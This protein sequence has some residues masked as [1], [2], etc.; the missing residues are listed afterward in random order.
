MSEYVSFE[1]YEQIQKSFEDA[2]WIAQDDESILGPRCFGMDQM[3]SDDGVYINDGDNDYMNQD[4][5]DDECVYQG[6]NNGNTLCTN[7]QQASQP[8]N[9]GKHGYTIYFD[10]ANELNN[11]TSLKCLEVVHHIKLDYLFKYIGTHIHYTLNDNEIAAICSYNPKEFI[12]KSNTYAIHVIPGEECIVTDYITNLDPD[13]ITRLNKLALKSAEP[14]NSCDPNVLNWLIYCAKTLEDAI[15]HV[16]QLHGKNAIDFSELQQKNSEIKLLKYQPDKSEIGF[17]FMYSVKY[18]VWFVRIGFNTKDVEKEWIDQG[19]DFNKIKYNESIFEAYSNSLYYAKKQIVRDLDILPCISLARIDTTC[20]TTLFNADHIDDTRLFEL[21]YT[22]I[23]NDYRDTCRR[24]MTIINDKFK[25]SDMVDTDG[26]P[27]IQLIN[28]FPTYDDLMDYIVL[29][30]GEN[31]REI[32]AERDLNIYHFGQYTIWASTFDGMWWLFVYNTMNCT[33]EDIIHAFYD[34]EY[35]TSD[36]IRNMVNQNIKHP[37]FI[38]SLNSPDLY[39]NVENIP[40][41]NIICDKDDITAIC[42]NGGIRKFTPELLSSLG[43]YTHRRLP[44]QRTSFSFRTYSYSY[45]RDDGITATVAYKELIDIALNNS[46]TTGIRNNAVDQMTE[47]LR[48]DIMRDK[49]WCLCNIE[50]MYKILNTLEFESWASDVFTE[51]EWGR[52]LDPHQLVTR[53]KQ[54]WWSTNTWFSSQQELININ[55]DQFIYVETMRVRLNNLYD[56]NNLAA[57]YKDEIFSE[58]S[59]SN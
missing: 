40:R 37:R 45:I 47:C 29:Y 21:T 10:D 20:N 49:A 42:T 50:F 36:D 2:E 15:H 6:D 28:F 44:I 56:D 22:T 34:K 38:Q 55:L 4:S 16:A 58:L 27:D 41:F 23:I 57:H 52:L 54:L 13:L 11:L 31:I 32:A 46:N 26:Y 17:Y 5:Q 25:D 35:V 12:I 7:D 19:C 43:N 59:V 48:A 18:D 39:Y 9:L 51:S 30:F 8:D 24:L 33:L 14:D 53:R 3:S 1:Q